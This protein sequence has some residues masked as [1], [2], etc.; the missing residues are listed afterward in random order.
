MGKGGG[1]MWQK[2]IVVIRLFWGS[3]YMYIELHRGIQYTHFLRFSPQE[4]FKA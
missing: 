4:K 3:R 1:V 2:G